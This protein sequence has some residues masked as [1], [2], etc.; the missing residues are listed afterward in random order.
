MAI[1][2][3][4]AVVLAAVFGAAGAGAAS[5]APAGAVAAKGGDSLQAAAISCNIRV[6]TP[7]QQG[8][9]YVYSLVEVSCN[10]IIAGVGG[11]LY[12]YRD[13]VSVGGVSVANRNSMYAYKV[14]MVSCVPGNYH[15]VGMAYA[16]FDGGAADIVRNITT[17]THRAWDRGR[18]PVTAEPTTTGEPVSPAG[19]PTRR[20]VGRSRPRRGPRPGS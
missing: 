4:F 6:T 2:L 20:P 1:R 17:A 14:N 11:Y 8:K 13:G 9:S 12:L 5:A 18:T 15:A 10:Q 3:F 19:R 7:T 16:N